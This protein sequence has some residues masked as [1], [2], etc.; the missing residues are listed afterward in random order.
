VGGTSFSDSPGNMGDF[1]KVGLITC[2]ALAMANMIGTGV[3]TSLGFQVQALHS[4]FLILLVW[5]L[6]GVVAFCGALS[7]AELSAALPR[8]GGEYNFLS[9]IYHPAIGFMS[10][11][12]S[13]AVGFSAPIALSAMALGKYLAAA[14]PGLSATSV[15]FIVVLLLAA[16][17]SLTVRASGNF[18][19]VITALKVAL[20]CAFI[21]LG[22]FF[23]GSLMFSP[24]EGDLRLAFSG[25]FA[26]S[27]MFVLYSYSG[28]NAAAYIIGEVREPQRTVPGSLLL[29]TIVVTILYVLL[30]AVFLA[31]GP[32]DAF[33]GKI[34][35]GEIAAR[36]LLGEQGGRLMA[37]LISGGLISSVSAMTWAGPRVAQAVGQDF[38]ALRFFARTSPGGVPRVAI[39]VQTLL[40]LLMLAT[41]TFEAVLLYAQ[42]SILACSFLT[43][44]GVI[45][46]RWREP[47]LRRPFRCLGYPLTPIVFL[48]LNLLAMVYTAVDRPEQAL[49]GLATL[50]LGITLYFAARGA[51]IRA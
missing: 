36:N 12:V 32:A 45:V 16:I 20:I 22:F 40:V 42:F 13:V 21:L 43:V 26:I 30:N 15:S 4:P 9:A 27:L 23:G 38:P 31:S 34:E 1:R 14:L 2:T 41:A 37:A 48:A 18:Q 24:H 6:G 8:S 17:H 19:V 10:G 25:P 46:L 29:A 28:W 51:K 35:V 33:A 47:G 39:G 7:Y 11:F 49:A 44:L 3:F 5:L 50:L